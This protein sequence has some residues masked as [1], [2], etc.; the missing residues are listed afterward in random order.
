MAQVAI[1][2]TGD[3]ASQPVPTHQSAV[4]SYFQVPTQIP[5]PRDWISKQKQNVRPWLLFLQTSNFRAPSS[6][7]RLS[8]RIMRNIEYFQSNYVFVFLGLVAYCL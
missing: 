8:K 6:I 2:V 5:D 1:D 3:M 7:P 4:A